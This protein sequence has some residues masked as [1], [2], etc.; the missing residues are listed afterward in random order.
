MTGYLKR[1]A[2]VVLA[3]ALAGP[4][5]PVAAFAQPAP[6]APEAKPDEAH[7]LAHA[8]LAKI[9]FASTMDTIVV[10]LRG[11]MVGAFQQQ[12]IQEA[13]AGEIADKY[14]MPEFRARMPELLARF[15]DVMVQDFTPD[16]L[17]AMLSGENNDARRSAAAK[18]GQLPAHF[19]AVGQAWGSQVGTEVFEKNRDALAKLG[20]NG[21]GITE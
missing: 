16:E 12:G 18:A 9:N 13:Q 3:A 6:V 11:V 4:A 1:A 10:S 17:R 20:V 14:M 7:E 8:F 19:Q 21:K 2:A 15:E 5:A